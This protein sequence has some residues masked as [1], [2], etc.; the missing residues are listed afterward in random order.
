[1]LALRGAVRVLPARPR[2]GGR[3]AAGTSSRRPR[4]RRSWATCS[5]MPPPARGS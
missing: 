5:T 1:V 4:R 2:P 3:A